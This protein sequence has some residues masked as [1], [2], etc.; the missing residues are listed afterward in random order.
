MYE[1]PPHQRFRSPGNGRARMPPWAGQPYSDD[2]LPGMNSRFARFPRG[3]GMED[4]DDD[5]NIDPYSDDFDGLPS[6]R[7]AYF[8]RPGFG[9]PGPSGRRV[10]FDPRESGGFGPRGTLYEFDEYDYY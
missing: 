9:G 7:R 3:R 6:Y 1:P 2:D 8:D 10:H 5:D 4:L